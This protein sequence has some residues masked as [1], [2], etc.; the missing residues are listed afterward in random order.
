MKLCAKRLM[1]ACIALLFLLP[2]LGLAIPKKPITFLVYMAADNNLNA[3]VQ[4]DLQ[5]MM[6]VGS[7]A[8]MNV[9]VYLNT[10]MPG[11]KKVTRKLVINNGSYRQDGPDEARD[12]GSDATLVNACAWAHNSYPSDMFVLVLWDHGSGSLNRVVGGSIAPEHWW[13]R[14]LKERGFAQDNLEQASCAQEGAESEN[15]IE[16]EDSSEPEEC[17]GI[18]GDKKSDGD[19]KNYEAAA[20]E[21]RSICYDDTTGNFLT[22][23]K[24][25]NALSKVCATYRQ[26]RKIDIVAFDACLMADIEVGYTMQLYVNYMVGSQQ[27]IPGDGFGYDLMLRAASSGTITARDFAAAMVAAYAQEYN[28]VTNDY[29]LS[30]TDLSQINPLITNMNLISGLLVQLLSNKKSKSQMLALIKKSA[31]YGRCTRFDEPSYVD[32]G[33]LYRNLIANI[34]PNTVIDKTLKQ[35]L[36][37]ALA[38]G[39]HLLDTAVFAQQKGSYFPQATGLSIYFD[40]RT[41]EYA[42]ANLL[43]TKNTQWINFLRAYT[44]KKY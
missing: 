25:R 7:N 36:L 26:G 24:L 2:S 37:A 40:M 35:Q 15:R 22:D 10:K 42:Y 34:T 4:G 44:G 31:D 11:Q 21:N 6:Q 1:R 29:T 41:I 38:Q 39:L 23:V 8:N 5:E 13:A 30:A 28:R 20:L 3:Y 12:S 32:I 16:L 33:H 18:A 17:S 9:L 14:V 43:W 27:T 19:K